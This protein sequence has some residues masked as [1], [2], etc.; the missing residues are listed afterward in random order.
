MKM[1]KPAY[2]QLI[3]TTAVFLMA[4]SSR[5]ASQSAETVDPGYVVAGQTNTVIVSGKGLGRVKGCVV[6]PMHGTS[7][8]I[9]CTTEVISSTHQIK[10]T[11]QPDPASP[12]GEYWLFLTKTSATGTTPPTP[13]TKPLVV[14]SL[15]LVSATQNAL[16]TSSKGKTTSSSPY[17][18]CLNGNPGIFQI[19]QTTDTS[20]SNVVCSFSLL[21]T[22][23][24]SDNFGDH[25]SSTYYAIQVEVANKNPQYSF[26]LRDIV[27]TL[28][29]GRLVSGRI[30]RFAQGV[31]VKGKQSDTRNVIAHWMQLAGSVYGGLS[32]FSWATADFKNAG[33]IYQGPFLG[34]LFGNVYP[35]Y[36]VDNINRFNNAVFDDQ[37]PAIVPRDNVGQPPLYVMALLPKVPGMSKA[38]QQQFGNRIGVAVEGAYI[39][40]VNLVTTS[41]KSLDFQT[42][43]IV[44]DGLVGSSLLSDKQVSM[45][46]AAMSSKPIEIKNGNSTPLKMYNLTLGA[47]AADS[48]AGAAGVTP[49]QS[50]ELANDR[51]NC[52]VQDVAGHWDVTKPF[53]IA[54]N[55]S[56]TVYVRFVPVQVGPINSTLTISGD[57]ADGSTSVALAGTG[58]GI[59]I[60]PKHLKLNNSPVAMPDNVLSQCTA[61]TACS[62]TLGGEAP[63]QIDVP[64]YLFAPTGTAGTTNLTASVSPG[65]SFTVPA[66]TQCTW[67]KPAL[68][69][70]PKESCVLRI[71]GSGPTPPTSDG[72]VDLSLTVTDQKWT[73][74]VSLIYTVP[75]GTATVTPQLTPPSGFTPDTQ[76]SVGIQ[77]SGLG[78]TPTG[79]VKCVVAA[80]AGNPAGAEVQTQSQALDAAGKAACSFGPLPAGDYTL[81]VTYSGDSNYRPQSPAGVQIKV[82]KVPTTTIG[83]LNPDVGAITSKTPIT[84]TITVTGTTT[85]KPS[86]TVTCVI[87]T[88][89]SPLQSAPQLKDGQGTCTFTPLSIGKYNLQVNYSG[90]PNNEKSSAETKAITVTQ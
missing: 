39:K 11:I 41:V 30:K 4:C 78:V 5:A 62:L 24:T 36:T 83:T 80:G 51:G 66:T 58:V 59:F 60:D 28:P 17:T 76:I 71:T 27:L 40:E 15:E 70:S 3:A 6:A 20:E 64:I 74:T 57:F 84:D 67:Q 10:A 7:A 22:R 68:S 2:V 18:S 14:T 85:T 81:G 23:E 65:D 35:D 72:K 46:K 89:P 48:T 61:P 38:Y 25:V 8:P 77:V 34:G 37:S 45:W 69:T 63:K 33:N 55:S 13:S 16:P 90:D 54:A 73:A 42:G 88:T 75:K 56:C 1:P 86:G 29:D 9:P 43:F 79:N 52:G 44:P 53:S 19:P 87:N 12:Q 31:A 50:F 26:L 82:P 47:V 21:T 32:V 49:T